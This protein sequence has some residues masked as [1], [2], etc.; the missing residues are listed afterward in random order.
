MINLQRRFGGCLHAYQSMVTTPQSV[1]PS[2]D[3]IRGYFN[4]Y[5]MHK[6][7]VEYLVVNVTAIGLI[8]K[9]WVQPL[10]ASKVYSKLTVLLA[11]LKFNVKNLAQLV[12]SY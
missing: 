9:K 11:V 6:V 8:N 10:T 4:T 1:S 12:S 5:L 7:Y 3:T 2:V